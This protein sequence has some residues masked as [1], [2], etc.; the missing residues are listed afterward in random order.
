MILRAEGLH[1]RVRDG[2]AWRVVLEDVSVHV[3]AGEIVA[4]IGPSGSGKST[5][6][7][8]LAGF[9]R[10]DAGTI[11]LCGQALHQ[12]DERTRT[13]ARRRHVSFLFQRF[14]LFAGLSVQ[15]NVIELACLLGMRRSDAKQRAAAALERLGLGARARGSVELLSGGEKQRV[16]VAR[17]LVSRGELLLCDEPTSALDPLATAAVRTL[18]REMAEQEGRAVVVATHDTRLASVADRVL[19]LAAHSE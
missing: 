1:K 14:H 7:S 11:E 6:L 16:A 2:R 18:L 13:R 9:E 10:P 3:Q 19:D 5:L 12:A 8:L 4:L 17:A 15:D